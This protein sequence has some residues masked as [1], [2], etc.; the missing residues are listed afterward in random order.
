MDKLRS[1]LEEL[2]KAA[3]KLRGFTPILDAPEP[4]DHPVSIPKRDVKSVISGKKPI[5]KGETCSVSKN[6]QWSMDKA[7]KVKV[8]TKP[9]PPPS[10]CT[11]NGNTCGCSNCRQNR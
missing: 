8:P 5:T 4:E 1:K 10:D 9:A 6:G 7:E 11:G 3:K 2:V